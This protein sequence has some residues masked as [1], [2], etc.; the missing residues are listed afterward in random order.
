M[1]E[2]TIRRNRGFA[3]PSYQGT[4][5]AE[6][7][8]GVSQSP[9]TAKSAG[10]TVSETLRQLMTR[11]S[12]AENH[13]RESRRTLQT[14]EAVLAE[15]RDSL[16]RIGELA[17][18]SAG[19]G[20][21]D[22]EALQSE[23]EQLRE[24]VDRML[25]GA[26]AGGEK[27]FLDGDTG[28][29]GGT[30]L[31]AVMD[32]GAAGR[33][34][35]LPSWLV[36]ALAQE[37]MTPERLLA[38]LG[39]DG[40]AGGPELLAAIANTS[41]EG[42][43]SAGYLAALYLGAVIAG[44][45]DPEQAMDGLRQLLERVEAGVPLDQAIE[46]LTRGEF[47]GMADFQEQFLGGTAPGLSDFLVNLLL[48]EGG[49]LTL[50]SLFALL[51]G[52]GGLNLELLMGLL[53]A[54]RSG[55]AGPGQA[56]GNAMETASAA[57][58]AAPSISARQLGTVQVM[59]Q[60]LSGVTL[61]SETGELV[62]GGTA[63]VMLQGLEQG[64]LTVRLTGS[65]QVT[66]REVQLS[67][68]T[69]DGPE[70]RIFSMGESGLG[71]VRLAAGASLTLAGGGLVKLTA[72]RAGETS[73]LRLE[74][75]AVVLAEEDGQPGTISIP[76]MVDG[77]VSLAAQAASVHNSAGKALTPFDLV[78]QTLLPGWS[79]ISSLAVDGRQTRMALMSGTPA[80]LWLEKGDQGYPVHTLVLR[81]RDKSGRPRT[82]YAY[83]RW[84]QRAK[85]FQETDMYPNP[86]SVTGGEPGRDWIYE[87]E[88]HTL[89]ILTN[90]VTEVAGG[91]G[92]D[93]NQMPF[94]GR[95][96]LSDGIGMLELALDGVVCRVSSGSAFSLGRGNDVTLIL[97]AG[98]DNLFES[99]AGCAGISLGE[100]TCLSIDQTE[101]GEEAGGTLTAS[102]ADGGAGI[103]RDSGESRDQTSHILIRGGTITATGVGG[104]AGIG[105]GKDGAMGPIII[106][107]GVITSTGGTGGGAGIGAALGA[108]A[109]DISIHGGTITAEAVHHAAAIGAGVQGE[110]GD[111]LITGTARIEKALGGDPGADIGACLF[112]GCGK[113]LI[114]GDADIGGARLWTQG[115]IPL[116]MGEDTVT[117]PRFRLSARTL[118][119]DQVSV[120][121]EEAA[122]DAE[123]IIDAD[124]R[125][126]SQIQTAYSALHSQL[127]QSFAHL[128][129]VYQ[130]VNTTE[131]AVRDPEKANDLLNDMRLSIL[132]Q[133]C[134]AMCLHN[135]RG[136]EDVSQLLQ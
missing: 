2:L 21:T 85:A 14:G 50:P 109:G 46:E 19:G 24:S 42:S 1:G 70:A 45:E 101:P 41:L 71:Q 68:L 49:S 30:P 67:A 92:R 99:G 123:E 10:Y 61:H 95:I 93:G 127:E 105:A 75:G 23:L 136:L 107:G 125:W 86:F 79:G 54:A 47:T 88:S 134:E 8:A 106:M 13:S 26:S 91:R 116:R 66:L 59:G 58:A 102:G 103:G 44:T 113:V 36:R 112:G 56:E 104:G 57:E 121:T 108:P 31:Y 130:Y 120:A 118:R 4:G 89:R 111:I 65:G 12:Q 63:D 18:R 96:A 128:Y 74:G 17:Q 6:K 122:R 119:L 126:V 9:K 25:S 15:V 39:L 22:R 16:D 52:T 124:R 48:P 87:E 117:L 77:P 20:K 115:G 62:I 40:T 78:W 55:E 114:S 81:G 83:L 53:T 33:E 76:L 28:P 80:R 97:R 64:E 135:K 131:E 94:S 133:S 90:Q 110:C 84:D 132:R 32:G 98:S 38:G 11:V 60:D 82:R 3:V 5:K 51:D 34:E 73:A 7:G 27:L 29:E 69:V 72:F 37:G 43:D 129:S 35:A 100:G